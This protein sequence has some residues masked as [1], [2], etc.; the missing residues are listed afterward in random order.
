MTKNYSQLKFLYGLLLL[1]IQYLNIFNILSILNVLSNTIKY[2]V[3][4]VL[5]TDNRVG[6]YSRQ[7]ATPLLLCSS[8]LVLKDVKT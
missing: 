7:R 2:Q 8:Q 3:L 1:I 6:G 5:S 4:K